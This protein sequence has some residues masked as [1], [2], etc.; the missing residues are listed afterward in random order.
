MNRNAPRRRINENGRPLLQWFFLCSCLL[1]SHIGTAAPAVT[2]TKA[3]GGLDLQAQT[4][5]LRD[6]AGTLKLSDVMRP[7]TAKGFALPDEQGLNFGFTRAVYWYR[8]SL[9]NPQDSRLS[10]WVL[11]VAWPPLDLIDLY[12][13]QGNRLIEHRPSGDN[14]PPGSAGIKHRNFSFPINIPPGSQVTLYLRAYIDGAHQFP[15]SIWPAEVFS[16]KTA[17]T[18][19]VLGMFY[20]IILV[21]LV[22]NLLIYIGVR[23]RVY[24]YYL[25]FLASIAAVLLNLD[26]LLYPLLWDWAPWLIDPSPALTTALAVLAMLIFV[27]VS[28]QTQKYTPRLDKILIAAATISAIGV[29]LPFFMPAAEVTFVNAA[30]AAIMT[31]L[32]ATIVVVQARDGRRV[33]RFYGIV[34]A[35]LLI[36][37]FTK[38]LQVNG[39]LPVNTFT[40]Y[41]IHIGICFLVTLLSLALV[42]QINTQRRETARLAKEAAEAE[43]SA[44]NAIL[45]RMSHELRTP[46]N[47]IIGFNELAQRE[48]VESRR[49]DHQQHI[50]RAARSLL[51][52]INE[53][54]DYSRF[55][56]GALKLQPEAFPL[57]SLLDQVQA[58]TLPLAEA[59]GLQLLGHC[60]P[61]LPHTV[62]GDA[63]RIG[64][65]L[66]G[67]L[68][69]AIKFTKQGEVKLDVKLRSPVDEHC[70][71]EF[72]VS[73]TGSGIPA[74]QLA[75]L[76]HPL[77]QGDE[78]M[79]RSQS[80]IGL[81][82]TLNR[83]LIE[84][85][86]GKLHVDS[87]PGQGSTF[88]FT[89]SLPVS[90]DREDEAQSAENATVNTID[91]SRR[92]SGMQVLL[93]EDNALNRRLASEMLNDAG[94][95]LDM[96]EDGKQAVEYATNNSYDLIFMDLQMPVTDGLEATRQIRALPGH[97]ETPIVAMTANSS[98]QDRAAAHKAG[99][100]GFLAKPIDTK[101]VMATLLRWAPIS[102]SEDDSAEFE[103]HFDELFASVQQHDFHA[104]SL[105]EALRGRMESRYGAQRCEDLVTALENFDFST[106]EALMN[107]MSHSRENPL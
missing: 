70:D 64:Q 54:L 63:T 52:L 38:V 84:L 18:D 30:M 16:A 42:D 99:M 6:E 56:A 96:A 91:P 94:L 59:K 98:P 75:N 60:D 77:A 9:L 32:T 24:P 107:E 14:R 49:R 4:E 69:N 55:E 101:H 8:V 89:L 35:A 53:V 36:G 34:W 86:G 17:S 62:I 103:S 27:R 106:A 44:R 19:M 65:V 100:N 3:G 104:Q 82:L 40:M 5:F 29:V 7:E 95:F 58:Q 12:V 26:G 25:F 81:G 73:D 74:E 2:L 33:A 93:A 46:M 87:R 71:I 20:G 61:E 21:M 80:G 51:K 105:C 43:S 78:S 102:G 15:V 22:Y 88:S 76:H 47:A 92:T 23:D 48:E 67:L 97:G 57:Q 50:D 85:M 79:T 10:N 11:E 45:G 37:I 83:R 68:D 28:L 41:P 72:S 13:L 66:L 31:L 1:F 39:I 90:E